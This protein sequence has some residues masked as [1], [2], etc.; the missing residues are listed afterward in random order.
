[1]EQREGYQFELSPELRALFAEA[2]KILGKVRDDMS[3]A[4]EWANVELAKLGLGP[5]SIAFNVTYPTSEELAGAVVTAKAIQ[6]AAEPAAITLDEAAEAL[7][8]LSTEDLEGFGETVAGLVG[9]SPGAQ[10]VSKRV[11]SPA[12]GDPDGK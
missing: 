8:D 1:M 7:G 4:I 2:E 6:Q 5:L 9:A 12:V 3:E 10:V 11:I